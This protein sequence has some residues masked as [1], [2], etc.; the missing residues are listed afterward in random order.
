M[1]VQPGRASS[2]TSSAPLVKCDQESKL[3]QT[4][5]SAWSR[6]PASADLQP[7]N[8]PQIRLFFLCLRPSAAIG[9]TSGRSRPAESRDEYEICP[10][11]L[12]VQQLMD[13]HVCMYVCMCMG[14]IESAR[15]SLPLAS[16]CQPAGALLVTA[17]CTMMWLLLLLR[18]V[19]SA[20]CRLL[21]DRP[22]WIL[23]ALLSCMV[24]Q[25]R[26][27]PSWF[28]RGELGRQTRDIET[29]TAAAV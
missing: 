11:G 4:T 23:D 14:T 25:A 2:L 17:G 28:A 18:V 3:R 12:A 8:E 20:S 5:S 6:P 10:V 19:L 7:S 15:R 1:N 29:L 16:R 13:Q 27:H 21:S 26:F 24:S 22:R 9:H